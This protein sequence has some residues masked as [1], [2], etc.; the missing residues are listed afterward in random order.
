M[1]GVFSPCSALTGSDWI[2]S[3]RLSGIFTAVSCCI[4]HSVFCYT[5]NMWRRPEEFIYCQDPVDHAGNHS[6]FLEMGH[7]CVGVSFDFKEHLMLLITQHLIHLLFLSSVGWPDSKR[8]EPHTGCL[9]CTWWYRVCR[10]QRIPQRK[11]TLH[12]VR[13]TLLDTQQYKSISVH[14]TS[15]H[16]NHINLLC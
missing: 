7:G 8:S 13:D 4:P 15:P 16:Q 1:T 2:Y 3:C 11:H 12:Q 9:H 10:T 14:Q 5:L 6:A